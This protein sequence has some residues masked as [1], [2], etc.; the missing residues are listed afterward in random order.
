VAGRWKKEKEK[1]N[2][3]SSM[4]LVLLLMKTNLLL[5]KGQGRTNVLA[6]KLDA[7]SAL[8]LSKNLLV[9]DST[10]SLVVVDLIGRK[11]GKKERNR[12]RGNTAYELV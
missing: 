3:A 5:S 12:K 2:Y 9:G 4:L 11:E 7:Q 1:E 6:T 8:E 10:S